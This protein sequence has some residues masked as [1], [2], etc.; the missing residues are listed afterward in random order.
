[1]TTKPEPRNASDRFQNEH[2]RRP[3]LMEHVRRIEALA[4]T[5]CGPADDAY[6]DI[7]CEALILLGGDVVAT[8]FR[9]AATWER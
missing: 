3:E 9:R 5:R 7:L 1:M 6:T 4:S 2:D 8:A